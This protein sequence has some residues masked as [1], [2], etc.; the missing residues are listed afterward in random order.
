MRI[1]YIVKYF[2]SLSE[3]F[4]LNQ[5]TGLI[6]EGHT[7]DVYAES[8]SKN[9]TKI[10][11]D[12]IDYG[13][14]RSTYYFNPP[15]VASK[16]VLQ[17]VWI[18]L[19]ESFRDIGF[20]NA[21]IKYFKDDRKTARLSLWRFIFMAKAFVNKPTYDVVH[22]HFGP[23]GVKG[24]L[25]KDLFFAESTLVT[26]F[27]GYDLTKYLSA[28]SSSTATRS[29][30]ATP[31]RQLFNAGDLFLPISDYWKQSLIKLGC[32]PQKIKIHRMGVDVERFAIAQQPTSKQTVQIL[33]IARL[34]EKKGVEY[35]IRAIRKLK[36]QGLDIAYSIVGEGPLKP[37]LQALIEDLE[38]SQDVTLL[39]WRQQHEVVE[40]L[41]QS[42]ILL[43]PSITAS[44]GD[45][46]GIPVVLME[47]MAMGLPVVSTQHSG[48]PELVEDG[49]AGFLVPEKAVE[50]TAEK[51][52]ILAKSSELRS[53]MGLNGRKYVEANFNVHALNRQLAVL[54]ESL[55]ASSAR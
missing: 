2:P 13:L 5:I 53:E 26:T 39:G 10:H 23:N 54:F 43:A 14:E 24:A 51:L 16:R 1:A 55:I 4:V 33:T 40:L 3:T 31:Y 44:D 19:T 7:V 29:S 41:S 49:T 28:G 50:A 42:Q 30:E 21:A 25:L 27:H 32:P 11:Q 34:C 15:A 46:E 52:T 20:L 37:S 18:T 35:G 22:A 48:I 47:A 17:G 12:V 36:D 9:D 45:K 6:D 38:L 8:P